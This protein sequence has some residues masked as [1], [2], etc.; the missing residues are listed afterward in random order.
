MQETIQSAG[1]EVAIVIYD[2]PLPPRYFRFTKR[3]IKVFFTVTPLLLGGI[4]LS[5]F[6]WGLGLRAYESPRPRIPEILTEK[7]SQLIALE[8][9]VSAL[10]LSNLQLS[11]KLNSTPV[12][13]TAEDPYLFGIKK[14]YGMQNLIK[15]NRISVDQFSLQQDSN[16]VS[17]KFQIINAASESKEL[18][19]VIVL[20][21]SDSI[22]MAYPQEV[23]ANISQGAKYSS[24]E[25]FSVSRLR[26]TNAEF[27]HRL[28]GEKVKFIIY[29]F[30]REG[31][32]LLQ[33]QTDS[34]AVE[35]K[36]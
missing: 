25:P 19:H 10:K 14:P 7:N 17:F 13:A 1:R 34:F 8:S 21:V 31:D 23:N 18:G 32:L 22:M 26:P 28:S 2:A 27:L 30:S 15:E 5:L 9:E 4:F 33:R 12:T 20:M 35:A 29:I 3:F 24:G 16:K 6:M 36:S 11:E